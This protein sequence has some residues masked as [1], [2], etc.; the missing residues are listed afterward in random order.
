MSGAKRR[1]KPQGTGQGRARYRSSAPKMPGKTPRGTSSARRRASSRRTRGKRGGLWS[2]Y[3]RFS[4]RHPFL[5]GTAKL[6]LVASL[7]GMLFLAG[8]VLFFISRV[9]DP[10]LATL[11]DRPP[12][13]TVLAADGSVLAE[14][15]LRRGH[16]RV[17]VLPDHLIKAVLATEDRRFYDHWGVDVG[18]LIR[19]SYRNFRA[20]SVVQGGST[21]TQ[22]LAKNL[23]LKPERTVMRKLE[24]L[25][26]TAWLEQRFTKDEILELYLN[27][28]YLGGGTYGVEAAA[29]HYFGRSARDVT[30]AQSAVIAGLLKAPSRYAP[31][32]SIKAASAR[33]QVVLDNMVEAGFITAAEAQKAGQQPLRLQAK[34][35]ATGYPPSIGSPSSCPNMWAITT[36]PSSCKRRSMRS[37]SGRRKKICAS[38]WTGRAANFVLA[39]APWSCSIRTPAPCG[40]SSEAAPTRTAPTTARSTRDGSRAP[41][42]SRLSISRRWKRD[43]VRAR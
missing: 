28:V 25:V 26:Y 41:R 15:G 20:G 40:R 35:D 17:D 43:T 19:A 22:Q 11:D 1:P 13:V 33:A 21:I 34:G 6:G 31:T 7:F 10:L 4:Q 5:M 30:L 36:M 16:I 12:N 3:K 42:S 24:E 14:R 8:A 9:P 32:R 27:R 38:C 2:R 37:C 29:R 18:G 39:R 23:F